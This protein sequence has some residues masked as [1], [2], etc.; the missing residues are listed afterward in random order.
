MA[1]FDGAVVAHA[2]EAARRAPL[3][4]SNDATVQSSTFLANRSGVVCRERH[5]HPA[6]ATTDGRPGIYSG[7]EAPK[8]EKRAIEIWLSLTQN[9]HLQCLPLTSKY[10]GTKRGRMTGRELIIV[11]LAIIIIA[12]IINVFSPKTVWHFFQSFKYKYPEYHEPSDVTYFF[13]RVVSFICVVVL[14]VILY[15]FLF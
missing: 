15:P 6:I 5:E 13:S 11:G 3:R 4:L 7:I 2:T 12:H 9:R 10:S 14:T 1:E 8:E